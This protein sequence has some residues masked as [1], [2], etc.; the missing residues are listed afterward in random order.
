MS[1]YARCFSNTENVGLKHFIAVRFNDSNYGDDTAVGRYIRE[2]SGYPAITRWSGTRLK[3][4]LLL[5]N[6]RNTY[7]FTRPLLGTLRNTTFLL[8]SY[9][10]ANADNL[11]KN[12]CIPIINITGKI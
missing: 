11:F 8:D 4:R 1:H 10:M 12:I 6:R 2:M 7:I 5:G 3:T 9:T